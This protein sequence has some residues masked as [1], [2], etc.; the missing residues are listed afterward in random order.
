[1][2]IFLTILTFLSTLTVSNISF[3]VG[4]HSVSGYVKS[5]GTTVKSHIRTNSDRTQRN[6]WTSKPN[7]N[8]YTG[9]AGTKTPRW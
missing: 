5:N 9:K 4:S 7:V 2:K 6:N 8:P 1:M 3:A